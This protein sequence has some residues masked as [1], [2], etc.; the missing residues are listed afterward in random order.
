MSPSDEMCTRGVRS[1]RLLGHVISQ[2]SIAVDLDKVAAAVMQAP[3]PKSM[4]EVP[5]SDPLA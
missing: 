3:A 4:Y 1:E 5:W 2:D